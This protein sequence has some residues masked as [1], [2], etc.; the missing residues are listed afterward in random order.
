[1]VVGELSTNV[2][3]AVIGGG[4]GG[5]V[6]AIRCAQ[7]GLET[8][9]IDRAE[10]GGIC[11]NAGCIPS[12]ALIHAANIAFD[13]AHAEQV[14]IKAKPKIDYKKMQKWKDGVVSGLRNGIEGLCKGYGVEVVKGTAFFRSSKELVV[15]TDH[16]PSGFRFKNAIIATGSS[17]TQLKGLEFDH[18]FIIDST[19]ALSLNV[20]PKELIVL[21]AGYIGIEMA[22][23]YAKLGSK[24]TIV[25]RG[26]RILKNL[27]PELGMEVQKRFES[28]GISLMLNCNVTGWIK[29]G[30]RGIASVKTGNLKEKIKKIPFD[31]LL[32]AVGH[33]PNTKELHL[34]ETKVK[35]DDKGFIVVDSER[36]T[37]DPNIFAVGDVAGSPML[38]HKAFR[39]GKIAAEVIAGQKSAFDNIAIPLVVFSDPELASTGLGEEE[40][41]KANISVKVSR[42]PLSA[43]GRARTMDIQG[44]K[45]GF[46]KLISDASS[47]VLLGA[48]IAAP[49][50]SEL[51]SELS[52]AIEMGAQLEDV[53]S[54]IHPHPTL[55]ESVMESAE[56]GLGKAVHLFAKK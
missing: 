31:K 38:A 46:V 49:N 7:L 9:L 39:E 45:A 12:K 34:D 15:E 22:I 21:G 36:R 28:L 16:G 32:V 48:H 23:L 53:A 11:T 50:A 5:Y 35:L 29:K 18:K 25:Y 56:M 6:A 44:A 2:D 3:V 20:I 10:L 17:P 42:F 1:M 37:Q 27:E 43:S 33:E 54:T 13:C 24:V 8:V 4:P 26:E 51:I 55:S 47:G 40:A 19:D 14:G 30:K 52:L 41:R